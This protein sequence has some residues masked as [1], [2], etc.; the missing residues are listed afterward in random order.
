MTDDLRNPANDPILALKLAVAD[1]AAEYR[2][3]ATALYSP[4]RDTRE[5]ALL[6]RVAL[7]QQIDAL[8]KQLRATLAEMKP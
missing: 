7:N 2:E 5:R 3:L 8:R 4:D 1:C 6:R